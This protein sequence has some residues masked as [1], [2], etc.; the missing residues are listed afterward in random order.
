V[1]AAAAPPAV[2]LAVPAEPAWVGLVGQVA[3]NV[4]SLVYGRNFEVTGLTGRATINPLRIAAENV[5][6]KLG[7]DGQLKLDAETN[8]LSGGSLPYASKL[9]LDLRE[10]EVGPIFKALDPSK[11]PTIEGRFNVRCQAEGAGRTL[12]DSIE[13]TQGAF[14]MQSR[15]GIF[16]GLQQEA[17]TFSLAARLLGSF[18][19][20]VEVMASGADLAAELAKQLAEVR[21]DQLNVR[22]SRDKSMNTR[23]ADFSLVSPVIRLQGQGE[24]T[25]TFE[26]GKSL[27]DQPLQLPVYM[28][29]MGPVETKISKSKLPVLSDERD[30]LGYLKLREPFTV[31]GTLARPNA[32]Q[33]YSQIRRSLI[34]SLLH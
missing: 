21:F 6:A 5:T 1:A 4:K 22:L 12:G 23:L 14:V 7:A 10:F 13:R 16:R 33:L 28:G 29:V 19:E 11:P 30:D 20:K 34:D 31:T 25:I 24:G 18:G 8:F 2:A 9:N 27:V 3:I 32:G 17:T 15:K 26:A